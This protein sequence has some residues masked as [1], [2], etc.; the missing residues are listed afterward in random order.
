M[1]PREIF[2]W[3]DR[4]PKAAPNTDTVTLYSEKVEKGELVRVMVANITDETTANKTLEIGTE[5]LGVH[6]PI[7]KRAAGSGNYSLAPNVKNLLLYEGERLYS[8]VYSPTTGDKCVFHFSGE[9]CMQ[10]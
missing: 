8:K 5:L 7:V 6:S 2:P 10:G 3:G 9:I 4:L 1:S